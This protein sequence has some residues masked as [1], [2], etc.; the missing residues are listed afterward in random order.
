MAEDASDIIRQA[1][2]HVKEI[3]TLI[4]QRAA[5]LEHDTAE[6]DALTLLVSC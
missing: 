1:L 3:R 4:F 2:Q 5:V 6:M